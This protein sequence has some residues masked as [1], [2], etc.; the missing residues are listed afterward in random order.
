MRK[1]HI[2]RS[3]RNI[4]AGRASFHVRKHQ[5]T[6]TKSRREPWCS[7][8]EQ[9]ITARA[10][11]QLPVTWPPCAT[12][13]PG[14]IAG[15]QRALASQKVRAGETYQAKINAEMSMTHLFLL[16]SILRRSPLFAHERREQ[17]PLTACFLHACLLIFLTGCEG[18]GHRQGSTTLAGALL[19]ESIGLKSPLPDRSCDGLLSGEDTARAPAPQRWPESSLGTVSTWS[20]EIW[21]LPSPRFHFHRR[22]IGHSPWSVGFHRQMASS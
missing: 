17:L 4:G 18:A 10:A 20:K 14:P 11:P 5:T 8:P 12:A 6:A 16:Q 15:R 13:W 19:L 1:R 3:K 2:N 9:V 21:G 22:G 7:C